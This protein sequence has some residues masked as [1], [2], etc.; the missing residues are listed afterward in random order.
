ML[1]SHIWIFGKSI[2]KGSSSQ[3]KCVITEGSLSSVE[4]THLPSCVLLLFGENVPALDIWM[5]LNIVQHHDSIKKMITEM[6]TCP[7]SHKLGRVSCLVS[8][9]GH[10]PVNISLQTASTLSVHLCGTF[11]KES[12]C[13][14]GQTSCST[15]I[16]TECSQSPNWHTF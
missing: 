11:K 3:F 7:I 1:I 8:Q 12:R 13:M 14:M 10:F 4:E 2:C 16:L 9:K 5:E 6:E 15:C